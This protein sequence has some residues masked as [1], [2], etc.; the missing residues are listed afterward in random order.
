[1]SVIAPNA[2]PT[3]ALLNRTST[4]P[5]WSTARAIMAAISSSA[6]TSTRMKRAF[7]PPGPSLRPARALSPV[8]ALR[9]AITT[10]APSI[11]NRRALARPLPDAPPVITATLLSRR[12]LMAKS[13]RVVFG[14][15]LTETGAAGV[16]DHDGLAR[17]PCDDG[18]GRVRRHNGDHARAGQG[19]LVADGDPQLA[20]QHVPHLFLL[21]MMAVDLGAGGEVPMG[22][23]HAGRMEDAAMPAGTLLAGRH[24]E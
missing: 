23:G 15:R 22:E 18:V 24:L 20:L 5:N 17:G 9:S 19:G 6:A 8:S 13:S 14:G 3:P 1:M 2:P 4:P 10:L 16:I 12:P 11:R 21:V 7:S